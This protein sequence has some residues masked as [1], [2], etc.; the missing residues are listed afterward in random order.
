MISYRLSKKVT[1]ISSLDC[2]LMSISCCET[3]NRQQERGNQEQFY[4]LF[5][6]SEP[7]QKHRWVET[8][9][10]PVQLHTS[11]VHQLSS[12]CCNCRMLINEIPLWHWPGQHKRHGFPVFNLSYWCGNDQFKVG[13][14]SSWRMWGQFVLKHFEQLDIVNCKAGPTYCILWE[15]E[16]LKRDIMYIVRGWKGTRQVG[17]RLTSHSHIS[18]KHHTSASSRGGQVIRAGTQYARKICLLVRHDAWKICLLG[19]KMSLGD[20]SQMCLLVTHSVTWCARFLDPKQCRRLKMDL[21][22]IV[23]RRDKF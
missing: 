17:V 13:F 5:G 11:S 1:F 8:V 7:K 22:E 6:A 16:N 18:A 20:R 3:R 9:P 23:S 19:S 15:G 4:P 2:L 10:G 14:G 21:K 12:K